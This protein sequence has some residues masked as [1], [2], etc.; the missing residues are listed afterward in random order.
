ML[1][2]KGLRKPSQIRA[3]N[4]NHFAMHYHYTPRQLIPSSRH[5]LIQKLNKVHKDN[6]TSLSLY[7]KKRKEILFAYAS[8]YYSI[9]LYFDYDIHLFFQIYLHKK[10]K[11]EKFQFRLI[12]SLILEQESTKSLLKVISILYRFQFCVDGNTK[13]SFFLEDLINSAILF[14]K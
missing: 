10:I 12:Y 4:Y 9:S 11:L 8:C 7:K 5:L 13:N 1:V 14:C 3:L 2:V 6:Y